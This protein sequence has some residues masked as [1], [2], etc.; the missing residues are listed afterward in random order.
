MSDF[1]HWA[2]NEPYRPYPLSVYL[3][4]SIYVSIY[5]LKSNFGELI[6]LE[7]MFKYVKMYA[8]SCLLCL[9]G[10]KYSINKC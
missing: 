1:N 4:L 10:N 6:F 5:H 8:Q 9:G 2:I 3:S 7:M